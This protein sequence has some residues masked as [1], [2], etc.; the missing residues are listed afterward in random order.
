MSAKW[1]VILM[2]AAGLTQLVISLVRAVR[3]VNAVGT[4]PADTTEW[5]VRK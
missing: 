4:M 2:S 5:E 1:F 3:E